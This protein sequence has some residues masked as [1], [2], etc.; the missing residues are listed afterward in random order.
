MSGCGP[1]NT[2]IDPNKKLR[3]DNEGDVVN[4]TRYQKLV[5]KLIYLSHT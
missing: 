4:I 3:D 5:G 1:A 2:S